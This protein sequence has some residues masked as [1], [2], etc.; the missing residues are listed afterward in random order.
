MKMLNNKLNLKEIAKIF[1]EN[2]YEDGFHLYEFE[3]LWQEIFHL[4]ALKFKN[5]FFELVK[6]IVSNFDKE[7]GKKVKNIVIG[8]WQITSY[9]FDAYEKIDP[10]K[11]VEFFLKAQRSSSVIEYTIKWSYDFPDFVYISMEDESKKTDEQFILSIH[12]GVTPIVKPN[13]KRWKTD[14]VIDVSSY[15]NMRITDYKNFGFL[16]NWFYSLKAELE[17]INKNGK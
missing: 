11:A 9:I 15:H 13:E 10:G 14:F 7:G 17:E 2:S 4:R 1:D 6:Y 12:N 3:K 8:E 5:D 16:G